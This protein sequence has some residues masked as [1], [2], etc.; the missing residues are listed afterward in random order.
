MRPAEPEPRSR[1]HARGL[2]RSAGQRA[3]HKR[4]VGDGPCHDADGVERRRD[5]LDPRRR[6][7]PVT[8]LVADDAAESRGP[9]DRA[10]RL[11]RECD[12]HHPC[13]DRRGRPGRGAAG[14]PRRV[15]R[16]DRRARRPGGELGRH[17]LSERQHPMPA[18]EG[19]GRRVDRRP[20]ALVDRRA[21]GRRH[22]VRV[23]DVLDADRDPV[24]RAASGGTCPVERAG[25]FERR[26]P[27]DVHPCVQPRIVRRDPL[28][29]RL[30]QRLGGQAAVANR[31]SQLGDRL[32]GQ[33]RSGRCHE[34][35]PRRAGGSAAP[36]F[37][38]RDDVMIARCPL[39]S[40]TSRES[41]FSAA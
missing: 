21:V 35:Q 22:V 7:R 4:R 24:Q 40:T 13:R 32:P 36:P 3:D 41:A 16:V 26:V 6:E 9:D 5:R 31:P 37:A 8:G 20:V 17:E 38:I 39:S 10:G 28:E 1:A 34:R 11:R 18:R 19:H 23:E 2:E 29:E 33:G 25:T 30:R 12:G 14:S 15:V 27:V